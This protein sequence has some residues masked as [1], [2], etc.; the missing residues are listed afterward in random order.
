MLRTQ[1][2]LNKR[3]GCGSTQLVFPFVLHHPGW[4]AP[5]HGRV[6]G[7]GAVCVYET[8][9]QTEAQRGVRK[10]RVYSQR[11]ISTPA[12]TKEGVTAG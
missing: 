6:G 5:F 10:C 12:P 11:A 2:V 9:R 3:L 4:I 1:L 7:W 8:D